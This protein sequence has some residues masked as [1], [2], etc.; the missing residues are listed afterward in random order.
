MF[1]E[2][3]SFDVI[4]GMDWLSKYHAV[5]V[6][7]EKM[8]K[9]TKDK[10]EHKRLEDVPTM[11]DFLGVFPKDLPGLQPTRQVEFQIDLAPN[12]SLVAWA[13]YRLAPSEMKELSDQLQELSDK[14]FIRL[15]SSPWRAMVL[16]VKKKDGSFWMFIDYKELNKLTIKNHYPL[17]RIDDL[18]DQLQ[19]SSVY[20]KID[21]RSGY[22]Q[23]WVREEDIPKTAFRTR[24]GHYE[25]QVM[26]FGLTNV[27]TELN[28]RQRRSLDL[29]NDYDC[30]I[31]YYPGKV[32]MVA[33]ALIQILNAQAEVM[34]EDDVKEENLHGMNKEFKTRPDGTLCIEKRSWFPRL[35]G[36]RDLIM[37]ELHKSKYF[38]HSGS[39][40]MYHD[41]KKLYWWPNMKA[42]IS[43]YL[44]N[45]S[46]GYDTLWVIVD[47]LTKS[48]HF[49]PLKETD[50]M[51]RLMRLYLK[52][53]VS[54]HGVST[55][56][57]SKRTFQI[58]EDMLRIC[59]I[60]FGN[61]WDKHLL[62]V[63]FSY[64]SSYHTS[65][66][67]APF[68]ALYE[69]KCRSLV[70]LAKVGDSQ[71]TGPEIIHE[72]TKKIIQIKSKIQAARDY[73]KSY[74]DVRRKILEFQVGD[75]VMLKV[76]PWKGV[77]HFGKRGKLNPRYIEPFK[78]LDKV[79]TASYRLD[80]PQQLSKVYITFKM[81]NMKKC[82]FDKSLVIPLDEI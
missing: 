48:T 31:R 80:L 42:E 34:K 5:I 6:C 7:D 73:Q 27:P 12:A 51:E 79:G 75:K 41:L 82:L 53:V 65:I 25:F 18:F 46:S 37:H 22:H 32:N 69:C 16:F 59:V 24:Y 11:R 81:S 3:G 56:G 50:T 36:L 43:T 13:P 64:N 15:S 20:S 66:K 45:T 1:V 62:L 74:A 23:L 52:E 4:I 17:P 67:A 29:L 14:V 49:L 33:D 77:I 2:H 30:E 21:L 60:D 72:T 10:S 40:K 70:C 71:L 8:F 78:I 47:R 57:Q 28:M 26:P 63:E 35:G 68:E 54:R 76:S 38:I 55:D 61:G 39:D 9:K 19:G 58:L 44:P